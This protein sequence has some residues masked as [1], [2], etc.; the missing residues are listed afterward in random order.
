L[1]KKLLIF[2]LHVTEGKSCSA[3]IWKCKQQPS[4]LLSVVVFLND[5]A[6][7]IKKAGDFEMLQPVLLELAQKLQAKH[8]ARGTE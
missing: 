8:Q 6:H 1:K 4:R 2:E 5:G 3:V 7:Y